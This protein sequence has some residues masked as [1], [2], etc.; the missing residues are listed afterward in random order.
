[1]SEPG[2][3]PKT[4]FHRR[5]SLSVTSNDKKAFFRHLYSLEATVEKETGSGDSDNPITEFLRNYHRRGHRQQTSENPNSPQ[6]I[7]RPPIGYSHSL[8][9]SRKLDESR[10]SN[11]SRRKTRLPPSPPS[12][13]T[14]KRSIPAAASSSPS[15]AQRHITTPKANVKASASKPRKGKKEPKVVLAP[16]SQQLFKGMTFYFVPNTLTSGARRMRVNKAIEYGAVCSNDWANDEITHIIAD[17]HLQYKNVLNILKVAEIPDNIKVVNE[18]YPG[19]C[20]H[21]RRILDTTQ[22]I[23]EVPGKPV[24]VKELSPMEKGGFG[25]NQEDRESLHSLQIKPVKEKAQEIGETQ[26]SVVSEVL[27]K[28]TNDGPKN[29]PS[30]PVTATKSAKRPHESG[31]KPKDYDM[32]DVLNEI[33]EEAKKVADLP[34]DDD[35]DTLVSA[36]AEV[37]DSERYN[38]DS[39]S[40]RR[41]FTRKTDRSADFQAAFQC[42][43]KHDGEGEH[44]NPNERTIQVLSEMQKYY[45]MIDDHWRSLS[46]RKAIT[47]LKKQTTKIVFAEEAVRLPCIG[48]RLAQKIEEIVF[49]NHLKRLDYAKLEPGDALLKLFLGVYGAGTTQAQRW[50]SA[51]HKT[52][53]DLLKKAK[54]TENQRIGVEHYDDFNTRIP[55]AEV[56]RHGDVVIKT[57]LEIDSKLQLDIMGSFRRGAKDCGDID[58]IITK[59]G[60]TNVELKGILDELLKRLFAIDFL[61]WT[62]ATSHRDDSGSKWHGASRIEPGARW[63]RL[64]FLLVPWK[65]RG[66]AL[67]YFT[68]NDIFNRSLRLLASKKGYR[69]NQRGLYKD[70]MR[71][72][73]RVKVT[74]G[75]LVEG[76]SEEKIFE[77]LGVPYRPPEHRI[78]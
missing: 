32:N 41:K 49:T 2:L 78:C 17:R 77:I 5:I 16:E 4:T 52:L 36:P 13:M 63:R 1:M 6:S 67:I 50:I 61:Q 9:G 12:P 3:S 39:A 31:E 58:I 7:S 66:A 24:S 72:A 56:Q 55:R 40:K 54:L 22:P 23:Y 46:Y 48:E 33:I 34:L 29:A 38:S 71:G 45:E 27:F 64:D 74:E 73:N 30:P 51:G 76:E 10:G 26:R 8:I 25:E 11:L 20:L 15:K 75:T 21:Y 44:Q 42:M 35:E 70:V 60:A 53:E 62:L 14:P 59:R 57:A 19:D 65:E 47:I 28:S 69:L 37:S 43:Y 68:G 18:H